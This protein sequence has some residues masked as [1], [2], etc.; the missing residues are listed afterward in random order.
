MILGT[1]TLTKVKTD[2]P[3]ELCET[4]EMSRLYFFASLVAADCENIAVIF[5]QRL[6]DPVLD[7]GD[8]DDEAKSDGRFRN[9]SCRSLWESGKFAKDAGS[10]GKVTDVILAF[11]CEGIG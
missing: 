2:V 4:G 11:V 1:M 5:S 9:K 3:K 7:S 8:E 6:G 10:R